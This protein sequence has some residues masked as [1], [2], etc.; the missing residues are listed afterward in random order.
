[1]KFKSAS[2]NPRVTSS[3]P[4]VTSSNP[5]V[6]SSNPRIIK[7]MKTKVNSLKSSSFP[8]II[9]PKLFGNSWGNSFSGNNLL[10]YV[11]TT[12]WLRLQQEAEWVNI[13]FE[14]RDLNSPYKSH[15]PPI[16]LGILAFSFAFNLRKENVTD[17]S[18]ISFT[19]NFKLCL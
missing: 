9:S 19:Q 2:S 18:S 8:K 16:I 6:T 1:M 11:S 10:F 17:F 13:N 12:P 3:N 4:R 14:R 7:S 5:W 15:L